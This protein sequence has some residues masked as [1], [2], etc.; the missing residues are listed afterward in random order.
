MA[1]LDATW[2]LNEEAKTLCGGKVNKAL[3]LDL[4]EHG[5]SCLPEDL[6]KLETFKANVVLQI[7]AIR[8]VAAP[9]ANEESGAAPRMLKVSMTDGQSVCHGLETSKLEG[10]GVNTPPGS[11]VK[12]IGN[13]RL[14][15]TG[16]LLLETGTVKLLG[17]KVPGLTDKWE[18]SRKMAHFTRAKSHQGGSGSGEGPPPWIP[19]GKKI[20]G[21]G[22][23][24]GEP[25]PPKDQPKE[26]EIKEDKN[27]KEFDSQRQDAIKEASAS[28]KKQFGGGTK[29]IK[30]GRTNRKPRDPPKEGERDPKRGP[31]PEDPKGKAKEET[32]EQEE[33]K[34]RDRGADRG[35]KRGGKRRGGRGE[36]EEATSSDYGQSKPASNVQLFDFLG[37]KF[38]DAEEPSKNKSQKPEP[39]TRPQQSQQQQQRPRREER[40]GND[41]TNSSSRPNEP[42][43]RREDPKDS[44]KRDQRKWEE[45]PS[46]Q[47][48]RSGGGGNTGERGGRRG[49][50]NGGGRERGG[51]DRDFGEWSNST[52]H[53]A[54]AQRLKP[55][56][57][58]FQKQ[59]QQE[60]LASMKNMNLDRNY[61]NGYTAEYKNGG[62]Y[63]EP[64]KPKQRKQPQ[65][66]VGDSC[67][68]KYW[69]DDQYYPVRVTAI[70]QN[71]TAVV[72]F[73]DYGNHEEVFL[74]DIVPFPK[75]QGKAG[76]IPTTPGLPPAFPQ[77][78]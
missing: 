58:N 8:N 74:D 15:S 14:S 50:P 3:D 66:Q 63:Q 34:G 49:K 52:Y 18:L 68:A 44:R 10:L 59:Q 70:S 9:K 20:K 73:I 76:F 78:Y 11:K 65:W 77:T 5:I 69:E 12:L 31:K 51:S 2:H 17:G 40:R 27:S 47:P 21:G 53:N 13:I 41:K 1:E 16:F 72:L 67:L 54:A 46:R 7:K 32:P 57:R 37:E 48:E 60:L 42:R 36:K 30:D 23:S 56:D 75:G 28:S 4:R 39:N 24:G 38:P 22:D 61:G 64:H 25:K 55:S 29:E 33:P 71:N 26:V 35:G 19:F 6:N 45:K 43:P 62:N